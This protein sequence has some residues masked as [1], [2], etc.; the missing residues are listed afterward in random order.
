MFWCV[1]SKCYLLVTL[2]EHLNLIHST[3][4]HTLNTPKS[5]TSNNFWKLEYVS[6]LTFPY[7]INFFLKL[8]LNKF[9]IVIITII[10]ALYSLERVLRSLTRC[11][12]CSRFKLNNLTIKLRM[13]MYAC[14]CVS[15]GLCVFFITV[16]VSTKALC[17]YANFH[18]QFGLFI[19]GNHSQ[20]L[21]RNYLIENQGGERKKEQQD[22]WFK[23][24]F[25]FCTL[26]K[27]FF[28]VFFLPCTKRGRNFYLLF[29]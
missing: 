8:K 25:A 2:F 27:G 19:G 24:C 20:I 13:C 10:I 5:C 14:A 22:W 11:S 15:K 9:I 16:A 7:F 4:V 3:D 23:L 21:L 26:R 28:N 29:F 6:R 17:F 18:L 12:E 1:L